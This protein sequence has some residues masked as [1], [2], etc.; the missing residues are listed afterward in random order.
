TELSA[1]AGEKQ[2]HLISGSQSFARL[3]ERAEEAGEE[4]M[5]VV[6]A[7]GALP[8]RPDREVRSP[9]FPAFSADIYV[10]PLAPE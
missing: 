9:G 10:Q 3:A 6:V 7:P 4:A 1:L 2:F 5:L 8:R